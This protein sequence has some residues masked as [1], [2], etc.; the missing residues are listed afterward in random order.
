V[1]EINDKNNFY[2]PQPHINCSRLIGNTSQTDLCVRIIC[3]ALSVHTAATR[4]FMD[5][6]IL[7]TAPDICYFLFNNIT[8]FRVRAFDGIY[9]IVSFILVI[10]II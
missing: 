9:P 6:S 7:V 2:F 8:F 1:H 4:Y 3:I 10:F 5:H